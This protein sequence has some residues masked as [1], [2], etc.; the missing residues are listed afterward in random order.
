MTMNQLKPIAITMFNELVTDAYAQQYFADAF[1]LWEDSESLYNDTSNAYK[2][3][4]RRYAQPINAEVARITA[5][6]GTGY[7]KR[8][9]A[10]NGEKGSRDIHSI[11]KIDRTQN[12]IEFTQTARKYPDGFI[13]APDESY[14]VA[15][16]IDSPYEQTDVSNTIV[17]DNE[18]STKN[19]NADTE[20]VD[21]LA[22]AAQLLAN[23]PTISALIE[24]CVFNFVAYKSIGRF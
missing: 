9:T 4:I 8:I 3:I 2:A 22:R 6:M 23:S 12:D 15:Q 7:T 13:A 18:S 11:G 21:T 10:N 14:I 20:E 1:D 17:T 24:S 19:S 16:T 5:I